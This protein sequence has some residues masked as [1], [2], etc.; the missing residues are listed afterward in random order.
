MKSAINMEGWPFSFTY[1]LTTSMILT[2]SMMKK[3]GTPHA[4]IRLQMP[5]VR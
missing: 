5:E 1:S 3:G 4:S 2:T